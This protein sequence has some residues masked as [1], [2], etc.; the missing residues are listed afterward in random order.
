MLLPRGQNPLS[1]DY[2]IMNL[3][4]INIVALVGKA[5]KGQ[6]LLYESVMR[7]CSIQHKSVLC[8]V[9]SLEARS[10]TESSKFV[11]ILGSVFFLPPFSFFFFDVHDDK[12]KRQPSPPSFPEKEV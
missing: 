10:L 2:S 3:N 11:R 4:I 6:N 7:W 5:N 1:Y 12:R 9:L 8:I